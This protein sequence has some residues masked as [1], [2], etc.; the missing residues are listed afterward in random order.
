MG[1]WVKWEET[2]PKCGRQTEVLIDVVDGI[3]YTNGERCINCKWVIGLD[4]KEED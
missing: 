1:E 4:E 2:C 3:E